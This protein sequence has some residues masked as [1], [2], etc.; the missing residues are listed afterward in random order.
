[1]KTKQGGYKA[2]I[3][4]RVPRT[5]DLALKWCKAKTEWV[6]HVYY[7]FVWFLV[8]KEDRNCQVRSLMGIAKYSRGFDFDNTIDWYNI[9]KENAEY[10]KNISDWI[11][12]FEQSII[13]IS[14]VYKTQLSK[15]G[16]IEDARIRSHICEKMLKDVSPE[17]QEKLY[18]YV[19]DHIK[20][21]YVQCIFP[22]NC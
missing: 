9:D 16:G 15:Y 7:H 12:W 11:K 18:D 13:P 8:D 4:D 20:Q 2:M 6:E 1:M 5:V 22:T 10:W 21:Y 19:I 3:R 14:E 17:L